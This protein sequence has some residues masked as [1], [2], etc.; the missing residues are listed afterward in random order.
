MK[1]CAIMHLISSGDALGS[2]VTSRYF[3][4]NCEEKKHSVTVEN[5]NLIFEEPGEDFEKEVNIV[6]EQM[7]AFD[8]ERFREAD[9]NMLAVDIHSAKNAP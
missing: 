3:N 6:M 4:E 5:M 9:T 8:Q 2:L 1:P 7:K